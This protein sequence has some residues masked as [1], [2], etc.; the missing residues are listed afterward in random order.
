MCIRCPRM[1]PHVCSPSP[2]KYP[3]NSRDGAL[4]C[5]KGQRSVVMHGR[6][7]LEH[8]CMEVC[9]HC[10]SIMGPGGSHWLLRCVSGFTPRAQCIKPLVWARPK[11]TPGRPQTYAWARSPTRAVKWLAHL[12]WQC[13]VAHARGKPTK[14]CSCKASGVGIATSVLKRSSAI[15]CPS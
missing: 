10:F 11:C 15:K 9:L 4:E 6:G 13:A 2:G 14:R 12:A 3:F 5:R 7:F 8:V 1:P